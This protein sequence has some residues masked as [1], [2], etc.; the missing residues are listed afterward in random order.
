[1]AFLTR[2]DAFAL[3]EPNAIA[4]DNNSLKYADFPIS[5]QAALR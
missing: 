4:V 1:M 2:K 3:L 5:S